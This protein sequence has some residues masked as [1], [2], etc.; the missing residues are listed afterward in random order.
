MT[1]TTLHRRDNNEN[2][3]S[4]HRKLTRLGF[5][6]WAPQSKY[7]TDETCRLQY[8]HLCDP[9]LCATV[10]AV[11]GTWTLLYAPTTKSELKEVCH[12]A[13]QDM[14]LLTAEVKRL[15]KYNR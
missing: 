6:L 8:T 4:V 1:T 3:A 9:G 2:T 11:S 12:G 7:G 5:S 15:R 10:G 13:P 14:S